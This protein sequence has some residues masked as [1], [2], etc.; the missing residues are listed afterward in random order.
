MPQQEFGILAV[1]P[2]EARVR[3]GGVVRAV[4]PSSPQNDLVLAV[5]AAVVLTGASYGL[6]VTAGWIDGVDWLEAAAVVTSYASTILC[7]RQRRSNYV[8]GAMSTAMY[9][10][11]FLGHGLLASA[12]LNVY[13]TP[14]LAY[15]WVRWR[16]DAETRP[17]T[18]LVRQWQWIPV[19]L[20]VSVVAYLGATWMVGALGG[21]LASADA[22][23]L[24]G[25]LLAQ[26][27][28]DN[29]RIET[30]F[31]WMLVNVVAIWTY[32][33]AGLV[34]AGSQYVVFLAT[35]VLGFRAWRR[36]TR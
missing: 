27:L 4:R 8:L 30:W 10:V 24:A 28:L 29:K 35:A 3:A 17:V 6:G 23:I 2:S 21:R 12:L 19:Y 15:G 25:S 31:V 7:I 26:F 1:I 20:G 32:F 11:L 34:V 9:A 22:A 36:S 14:Q 16:R 5:A 33:M 18:W 13:L